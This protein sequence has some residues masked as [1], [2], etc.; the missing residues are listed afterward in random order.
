MVKR[1]YYGGI[2]EFGRV[3]VITGN[4]RTEKIP[5]DCIRIIN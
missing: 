1:F 4:Q 5:C 2:V 3:D